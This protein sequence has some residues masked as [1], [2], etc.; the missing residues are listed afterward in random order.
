M[1]LR[2]EILNREQ[3]P[4]SF[5]QMKQVWRERA[6]PNFVVL[7]DLPLQPTVEDIFAGKDSACLLCNLHNPDGTPS[8]TNHWVCLIRKKNT[9]DFFDSLGNS[10]RELTHHLNGSHA[11]LNFSLKHKLRYASKKLQRFSSKVNDCGLHVSCRILKRDLSPKD[12]VH[13]LTH[14]FLRPDISVSMLCF[15]DLIHG[16]KK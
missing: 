6:D 15:L 11:L 9:I 10:P 8:D 1:T 7:D 16:T 5:N 12:Y 3:T 2:T 4:V 14:G 13:W